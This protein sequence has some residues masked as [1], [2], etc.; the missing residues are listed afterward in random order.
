MGEPQ[1][2]RPLLQHESSRPG[3]EAGPSTNAMGGGVGGPLS[4]LWLKFWVGVSRALGAP[5]SLCSQPA[6]PTSP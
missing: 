5:G 2:H 4:K 6:G 3:A 1:F